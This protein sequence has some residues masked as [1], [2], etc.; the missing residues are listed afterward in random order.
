MLRGVSLKLIF[1]TAAFACWWF[2]ESPFGYIAAGCVLLLMVGVIAWGVFHPNSPLWA[3][4]YWKAPIES[5]SIALTFD[6]GP[7][8]EFTP[9]LLGILRE[10]DVKA[11]FF[12]IGENAQK[13]PAV[14]KQIVDA[15]HI[16]GNHSHTHETLIN[17][18][19]RTKLKTNILG[20]NAVIEDLAGVKPRMYRPPFGF[21]NPATGDVLNDLKM[22]CIGWQVRAFDG[23]SGNAK[24]IAMRILKKAKPGG[25]LL[26]HDG[27]GPQGKSDRSATLE[28]LPLIIDG[29]RERGFSFVRLDELL[30]QKPYLE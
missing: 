4:T 12:V 13:A 6:D 19:R 27:A 1:L 3:F 17:V 20:C 18:F 11:A 21:K 30:E 7:D 26:M 28:A 9:K 15:G 8:A 22:I 2:L 29:I 24:S 10:K 25:V 5:D 14:L 16:L 23:V